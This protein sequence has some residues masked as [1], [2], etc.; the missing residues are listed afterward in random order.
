PVVAPGP[1]PKRVH[2]STTVRPST[3]RFSVGKFEVSTNTGSATAADAS[4]RGERP[5]TTSGEE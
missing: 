1:P 3:E 5:V 4:R 2:Q